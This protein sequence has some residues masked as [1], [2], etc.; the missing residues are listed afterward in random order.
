M[1]SGLNSTDFPLGLR[2]REIL[3]LEFK[4]RLKQAGAKATSE[5]C[6]RVSGCIERQKPQLYKDYAVSLLDASMQT[7]LLLVYGGFATADRYLQFLENLPRPYLDGMPYVDRNSEE[8]RLRFEGRYAHWHNVALEIERS[9][10]YRR[11]A[12][13]IE[14]ISGI[15]IQ[16][17][18][19]SRANSQL[20]VSGAQLS[21][22]RDDLESAIHIDGENMPSGALLQ[23]LDNWVN[24]AWDEL[25]EAVERR[26]SD[27][28]IVAVAK[29]T[30]NQVDSFIDV[31]EAILPGVQA[32][33]Y[34]RT[35]LCRRF[36]KQLNLLDEGLSKERL[37][38][39]D[40]IPSS[41]GKSYAR[42]AAY[43]KEIML[44]KRIKAN[45]L[46]KSQNIDPK[47]TKKILAGEMVDELVLE[48][49]AVALGVSRDE[50]PDE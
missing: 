14:A 42:R 41:T 8:M 16:D 48:K 1:E 21:V 31:T 29:R 15:V 23:T 6:E 11:R 46:Y 22:L 35:E 7:G 17:F 34:V 12:K 9:V 49:L 20:L 47:T 2:S 19:G 37:Q 32:G 18:I 5:F 10:W 45:G 33:K 50:I 36:G 39:T 30:F 25:S 13:Q 28:E 43:I 4:S 44:R 3:E 27:T 40:A 38:L 24:A 26:D